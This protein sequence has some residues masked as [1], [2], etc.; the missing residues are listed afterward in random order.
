MTGLKQIRSERKAAGIWHTLSAYHSSI[1][2]E[3]TQHDAVD[4]WIGHME[5]QKR[6][7]EWF[8]I[9]TTSA[10]RLLDSLR[11]LSINPSL[12]R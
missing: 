5:R 9:L 1:L 11:S 10:R 8:E 3:I 2:S 7:Q 6:R 4:Y 12:C